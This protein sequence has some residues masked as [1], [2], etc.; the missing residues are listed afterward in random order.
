MIWLPNSAVGSEEG[1]EGTGHPSRASGLAPM[2]ALAPLDSRPADLIQTL[3]SVLTWNM[4][5]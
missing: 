2:V 5:V 1:P 4:G 3:S